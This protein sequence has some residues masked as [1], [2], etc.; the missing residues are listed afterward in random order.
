[1]GS[2]SFINYV[3]SVGIE[4]TEVINAK[5]NGNLLPQNI[6]P[7]FSILESLGSKVVIILT[8]LDDDGCITLTKKR[9][10][11]RPNDIVIIAVKK[12]EAWFLACTPSMHKLLQDDSFECRFPEN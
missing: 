11:A 5:G 4:I 10:S 1:M 2:D 12:I 8:D 9:I 7:F 3:A 6:E